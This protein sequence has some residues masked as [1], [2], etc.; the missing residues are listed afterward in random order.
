MDNSNQQQY[1]KEGLIAAT[2]AYATLRKKK[3]ENVSFPLC[4]H[5]LFFPLRVSVAQELTTGQ[6][7]RD[8]ASRSSPFFLVTS[9]GKKRGG[10][11][12]QREREKKKRQFSSSRPQENKSKTN[13]LR[14]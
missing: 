12:W 11:K 10:G 4:L 13:K 5:S 1:K 14:A 8:L 7:A 3:K 6:S 9:Q 2:T